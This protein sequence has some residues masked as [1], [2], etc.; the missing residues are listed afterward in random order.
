[1]AQTQTSKAPANPAAQPAPA[2]P[3]TPTT[4][5]NQFHL[6]GGGI[7]VSY[8]PEGSGPITTSGPIRLIYQDAQRTLS[9]AGGDVRTVE[10]PD[11][12][13]V[14]SVTLV[15]TVDLGTTTFSLVV[16][17]VL[18]PPHAA[19]VPVHTEGVTTVHRTFL[20]G[21]G[22]AQRETYTVTPLDG[23]ASR[24]ILPL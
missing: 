13:T 22:L 1:M 10:V 17:Q 3:A 16:P 14:V 5:P 4:T 23:T 11:L 2:P 12:G 19:P 8:F 18:V 6:H 15:R 20:A 21:P 7:A 9:F 24:G